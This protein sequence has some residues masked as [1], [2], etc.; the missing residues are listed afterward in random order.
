MKQTLTLLTITLIL[1]SNHVQA[2]EFHVSTSEAFQA[3]L[4]NAA[5]NG[6]DDT[7]YLAAGI[8]YGNFRYLAKEANALRIQTEDG[9]NPGEVVL[10]GG[11]LAYVL[12]IKAL[13]LYPEF[14]IHG[15]KF[16]RG[17]ATNGGG[18]S[19]ET[20]GVV[21]IYDSYFI[22]N[23]VT[24]FGGGIYISQAS[25]IV[26]MNNNINNNN[27]GSG[28]FISNCASVKLIN[29]NLYSNSSNRTYGGGI[30]ISHASIVEL[31]NNR[32]INN[33]G[34][35]TGS[36][37]YMNFCSIVKIK[38]NIINANSCSLRGAGVY[39]NFAS[40]LDESE[41]ILKDNIINDN[42]SKYNSA[43]WINST[44]V[45]LTGNIIYGHN[46]DYGVY[47]EA[48]KALYLI[49]NTITQNYSYNTSALYIAIP[50]TT[51]SFHIYNSIFWGNTS[52]GDF[53]DIYIEGYGQELTA[54]NNIFSDAKALWSDASNNRD[55]DPLF[56][57]PDN[58]DF[59]LKP[60]SPCINAG[61]P[62]APELPEFDLDGNP[63]TDIPDIGAYEFT[64]NA[65]HPADTDNNWTIDA[66]EFQTYNTHWQAGKLWND[67]KIPMDYATIAGLIYKKGQ[68]YHNT[69]AGKPQ[70]WVPNE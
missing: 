6:G 37:I 49:N 26:C 30:Y 11:K 61:N 47:I 10:D 42:I 13:N 65:Q 50:E 55:I 20:N 69:G 67:Q 70:C 43:A 40:I 60:N 5:N 35:I 63:R 2:A 3:A 53:K 52:S 12:L 66:S 59:H 14:Y 32:I 27:L 25:K 62:N 7:I 57:D 51:G 19:V 23:S 21:Y 33:T 16:Q 46:T 8:Y 24:H 34:D 54:H 29:N 28:V 9:V 22:N 64:D 39:I 44:R 36:G 48:E 31:Y 45:T 58:N 38:N 17:N 56:F 15:I 18:L 1:L 41:V 4:S 68:H